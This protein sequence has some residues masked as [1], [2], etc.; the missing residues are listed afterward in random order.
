MTTGANPV[1]IIFSGTFSNNT[2]GGDV[3]IE[4][5][6]DYTAYGATW[7]KGIS[8]NANEAFTLSFSYILTLPAGSHTFGIEWGVETGQGTHHR[9]TITVIE[10][11]R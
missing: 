3:R 6:V 2:A 9:S 1:L 10:L 11:K 4:L 7:R 5:M 8:S